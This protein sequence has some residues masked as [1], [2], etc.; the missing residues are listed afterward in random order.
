MEAVNVIGVK[1]DGSADLL[2]SMPLTPAMKRA[3]IAREHFGP[4][5]PDASGNDA[6]LCLW[7][8][9]QY[10]DWLASQGWKAPPLVVT[11]AA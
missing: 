11:P 5:T 10:H 8:I 9:E 7:A 2:G 3:D 1:A 6:D 4:L